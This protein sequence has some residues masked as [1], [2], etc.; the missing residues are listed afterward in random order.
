MTIPVGTIVQALFR[1]KRSVGGISAMVTIEESH[2]DEMAVTE[3]PVEIGANISDHAFLLPS[4]VRIVAGWSKSPNFTVAGIDSLQSGVQNAVAAATNSAIYD[5]FVGP[6]GSLDYTQT[7]YQKF[8]ELM[9][10]RQ[11]FDIYTGKR[12]YQN[13]LI[14]SIG[15][16]TTGETENAILIDMVC[17]QVLLVKTKSTKLSATNMKT[18]EQNEWQIQ[19]GSVRPSESGDQWSIIYGGATQN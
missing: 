16:T 3:H 1:P 10:S 14:R 11:P 13:M 17:R 9:A 19:R 6:G 12:V 5:A 2:H 15:T 4:E 7:I 8:R 18:P